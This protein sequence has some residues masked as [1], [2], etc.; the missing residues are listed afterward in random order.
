MKEFN[1]GKEAKK[2]KRF[3]LMNNGY[4]SRSGRPYKSRNK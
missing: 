1:R 3:Y 4:N 2:V